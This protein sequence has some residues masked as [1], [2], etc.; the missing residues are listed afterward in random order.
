MTFSEKVFEALV[1]IEVAGLT[2]VFF[3]GE[4][5]ILSDGFESIV[6]FYFSGD[7]RRLSF[8]SGDVKALA[9]LLLP[10]ALLAYYYFE[11]LLEDK[12]LVTFFD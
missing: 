6:V 10:K 4:M 3:V 9:N 8:L 7:F 12:L 5:F 1:P 2:F 11:V